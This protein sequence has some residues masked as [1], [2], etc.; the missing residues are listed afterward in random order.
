[1][2]AVDRTLDVLE[3]FSDSGKPLLLPDLAQR[4]E[5][6]KSTCF[7]IVRTL[8]RRGY[9]YSLGK[10]RGF[11]PT[12]RWLWHAEII[13]ANDPAARQLD[14][15]MEQLRD[16]TGETVIA[17]RRQDNAVVYV[18]AVDGVHSIRYSTV[19][20]ELKPLHSSAI[21]KALLASSPEL[22]DT[23]AALPLECYTANTI[24]DPA[25]LLAD[26]ARGRERGYF[27]T[28]GENVCDVMAI[29]CGALV[30]GDPIAL[31]VAGPV[32]RM[33]AAEATIASALRASVAEFEP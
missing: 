25:T 21:G 32:E 33:G 19:P 1:M 30:G 23:V 26:L 15:V 12:R 29:A 14:Q 31:A 16:Q 10:R 11:Y 2:S 27:T 7:E 22:A 17:G 28:V 8:Q 3:A 20:G 9:L 4:L 13:A 18:A 6:P 24:C 5:A